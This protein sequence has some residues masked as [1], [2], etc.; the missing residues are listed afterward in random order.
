MFQASYFFR[1]LHVFSTIPLHSLYDLALKDYESRPRKLIEEIRVKLDKPNSVS[2]Q[3]DQSSVSRIVKLVRSKDI[4]TSFRST[5]ELINK[6]ETY[7]Q[8]VIVEHKVDSVEHKVDP[9]SNWWVAQLDEHLKPRKGGQ[10]RK[11]PKVLSITGSDEFLSA[12]ERRNEFSKVPVA[13]V[14]NRAMWLFTGI[15]KNKN[16]K[17]II[18]THG[19]GVEN[20]LYAGADL[21]RLLLPHET[22][23]HRQVRNS[24][25]E[26]FAFEVEEFLER[27]REKIDMDFELS[28]IELL[29]IVPEGQLELDK[30]FCQSRGFYP[31]PSER[32]QEIRGQL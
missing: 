14:G 27:K 21:E 1:W 2:S 26:W 29:N 3:Q 15:P 11:S 9:F 16:Y 17:D 13:F 28:N 32:V 10:S 8:T 18:W 23:K 22:W 31:P 5:D 30:G 4:D 7:R 25:I 24:V 6:L 20:D 19:Y 12:Y